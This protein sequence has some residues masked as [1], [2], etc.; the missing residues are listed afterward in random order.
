MWP[1]LI[2]STFLVK[3]YHHQSVVP[4]MLELATLIWFHH[5]S[6]AWTKSS[7]RLYFFRFIPTTYIHVL[8][9]LCWT[10][11]NHL[12]LN[13]MLSFKWARFY[14]NMQWPALQGVHWTTLW[15]AYSS[16][17]L[18]PYE[19]AFTKYYGH[20]NSSCPCIDYANRNH[21]IK[22]SLIWTTLKRSK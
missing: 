6:L 2:Q 16:P 9:N 19:L 21:N 22:L 3:L 4:P 14:L 12:V 18:I 17:A 1:D 15:S 7:E 10:V 8:F 20:P 11:R 5:W 13:W